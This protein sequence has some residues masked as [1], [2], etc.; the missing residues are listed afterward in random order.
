MENTGTTRLNTAG[1]MLKYCIQN[2]A[3][4]AAFCPATM[5]VAFMLSRQISSGT[6]GV[7]LAVGNLLALAIQPT[8]A[9]IADSK[10]GPTIARMSFVASIAMVVMF[11]GGWAIP[12]QILVMA[13]VAVM[14]MLFMNLLG[15][16]NSISVYYQNRGAKI[17]YGVA[18]GIGS[19]SYA[20][21]AAVIGFLA[22]S[23]GA[24]VYVLL[25][26]GLSAV[27]ALT[28]LLLPTPKDVP[29][30]VE[31]TAVDAVNDESYIEFLKKHWKFLLLIVGSALGFV[32]ESAVGTYTLPI[33]QSVGGGEAE[34]GLAMA[35][36]AILELPGMWGYNWLET[37]FKTSSLLIFSIIM[38]AVKGF[39]FVIAG[40]IPMVYLAYAFQA[41]SFAIF[42]PAS[43]SY[44]N[45][46]FGEGDKNKAI[47]L[48][49][50]IGSIAGIIA[51]PV[52][53]WAIDSFGVHMMLI[54]VTVMAGVGVVFSFLGLERE[55][56]QA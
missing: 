14:Y 7:A 33:M 20:G 34:M 15:L 45:K 5:M 46:F 40:N 19:A 17:N 47:G 43:I 29:A 12:N 44:A 16:I 56:A 53:G 38:Y 31:T 27:I 4:Q 10:T 50:L 39:M 8:V 18:R 37:K 1:A 24:D 41:V 54:I 3:A 51:A 22:D 48:F 11:L 9:S 32:M 28:M 26:A 36:Q 21:V 13:C 2:I 49:S 30:L 42:T 25:G 55:K 52:S 35:L 23:F 6:A